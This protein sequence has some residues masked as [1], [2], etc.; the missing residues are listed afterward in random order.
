M[1][2]TLLRIQTGLSLSKETLQF[3][4]KFTTDIRLGYFWRMARWK[5]GGTRN[6]N[7]HQIVDPW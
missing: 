4:K 3:R 7:F 1:S 6:F 5:L 2:K